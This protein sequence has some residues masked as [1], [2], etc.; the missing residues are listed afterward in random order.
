MHSILHLIDTAGPGGAETVYLELVD[1]LHSDRW[2]SVPVTPERDWLT[3]QLT[4]RGH[5]PVLEVCR[6]RF[7]W[8]YLARLARLVRRRSIDVIHAHLFGPSLEA[9]LVSLLTGV[10]VVCTLHGRGDV[11]PDERWLRLKFAI[12]NRGASRVVFVSESLRKHFLDR[13]M[14]RPEVTAVIPNGVH[15]GKHV[16]DPEA[17]SLPA[18][19][20][21]PRGRFLIGAVGNL[22]T[23]KRYDVLLQAA[24]ILKESSPDV[25]FLIVGQAP[26]DIHADLLALRDCLGLKD[27]V[28]FTGFRQDVERIL[29]ALDLFVLTSDTEG[30]S[31]AT[32]QAMASKLPIVATRCGGPEEIIEHG[33]TGLLVAPGSPGEIAQAIDRLRR[34]PAASSALAEAAFVEASARFSLEAQVGHYEQLYEQV[35]DEGRERKRTLRRLLRRRAMAAAPAPT[36]SRA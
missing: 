13:G 33:R 35:I 32:V 2:R 12:L 34:D 17:A 11:S 14:L 5:E 25:F 3:E 16:V 15:F 21:I 27:H 7:D 22:R 29:G 26:P 30:F 18:D 31:I 1:G 8:G 6:N 23:V 24:A 28:H 10:P 9:S 20:H 36:D 19:L 4:V